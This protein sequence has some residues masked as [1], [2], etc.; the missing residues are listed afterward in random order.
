MCYSWALHYIHGFGSYISIRR[1][2]PCS[3]PP[4]SLLLER[5]SSKSADRFP[6]VGGMAPA[7]DTDKAAWYSAKF[8]GT[9]TTSQINIY[10]A[11]MWCGH[12]GPTY[13]HLCTRLNT[14]RLLTGF[15]WWHLFLDGIDH[16][17]A[18]APPSDALNKISGSTRSKL[19][20]IDQNQGHCHLEHTCW[21]RNIEISTY[22]VQNNSGIELAFKWPGISLKTINLRQ[23]HRSGGSRGDEEWWD[24]TDSR[25]PVE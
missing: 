10:L 1:S 22:H 25:S 24:E 5:E 8:K 15:F 3:I 23:V 17:S 18:R 4:D 16:L 7:H 9:Q 19:L 14:E 21:S 12:K 2:V 6:T 20:R 11:P 13:P